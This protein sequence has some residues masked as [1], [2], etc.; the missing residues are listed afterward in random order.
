[1]PARRN[2]TVWRHFVE[3]VDERA[4]GPAPEPF[5]RATRFGEGM[6]ERPSASQVIIVILFPPAMRTAHGRGCA[7]RH[8]VGPSRREP[9]EPGAGAWF[10][11]PQSCGLIAHIGLTMLERE[12]RIAARRSS[13]AAF[14]TALSVGK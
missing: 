2:V 13:F 5:R 6:P 3:R 10:T 1:M 4:D 8:P 9:R 11:D 14:N 12:E 7:S